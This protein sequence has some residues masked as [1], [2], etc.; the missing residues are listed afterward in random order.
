M[1][2][3]KNKALTAKQNQISVFTWKTEPDAELH[4]Q[5]LSLDINEIGAQ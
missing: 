2:D 5:Q 4:W 3:I 1:V